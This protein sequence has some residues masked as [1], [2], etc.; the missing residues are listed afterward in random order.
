VRKKAE[1]FDYNAA[2][3][4][5][6]HRRRGEP[7]PVRPQKIEPRLPGSSGRGSGAA[8]Q[9]RGDRPRGFSSANERPRR[10]SYRRHR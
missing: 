2:A 3:P 7:R 8:T 4:E 10:R 5:G 6:E 1:G 9:G